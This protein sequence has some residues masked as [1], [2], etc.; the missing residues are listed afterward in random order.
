MQYRISK[1]IYAS[2][3]LIVLCIHFCLFLL[4]FGQQIHSWVDKHITVSVTQEDYTVTHILSSGAQQPT[5]S[6]QDDASAQPTTDDQQ[7]E[8]HTQ[9]AYSTPPTN[10]EQA[11]QLGAPDTHKQDLRS[12]NDC[13]E[14]TTNR[15]TE[16]KTHSS[17]RNLTLADISRGF[18][19]SVQQE[20]GHNSSACN[21]KELALQ[22]YA[23]KVWNSIKNA[24]LVGE[25]RLRLPQA[26]S[27]R[28]QLYVTINRS[29]QL[30]NIQLAYPAQCA[31]LKGI[32]SLLI[33]RAQEVGLFPPFG[34]N[35]SGETQRFCFPLLIQGEEGFHSYSLRYK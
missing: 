11:L 29:G 31:E 32:E 1:L 24:F 6:F 10:P 4:L 28:T 14:T 25:N 2:I 16:R 27:A 3:L 20:S 12:T 33:A 21:A 18:M 26:V 17:P 9:A 13:C 30:V 5:Q 15:P 34:T 19:R 23:S 35:I 8:Q 22:I 7:I